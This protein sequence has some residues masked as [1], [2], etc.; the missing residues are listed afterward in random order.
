MPIQTKEELKKG[1]FNGSPF[2]DS[3]Q[4]N[5]FLL[6]FGIISALLIM[7]FLIQCCREIARGD[8]EGNGQV[9]SKGWNKRQRQDR[10]LKESL[11]QRDLKA[12]VR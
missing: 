5:T 11:K 3:D 4:L 1:H 7:A 8:G 2:H 10:R 9:G 6:W 12:A